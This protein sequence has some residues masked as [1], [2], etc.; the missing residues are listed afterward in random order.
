MGYSP[1]QDS[2]WKAYS[3]AT[4]IDKPVDR[5]YT[6]RSLDPK[7]DPRL[8]TLRESCDSVDH[9]LSTPI[10]IGLDVTGS[11]D[12]I[13]DTTAQKL[14]LLVEKIHELKP[15]TDP[16]IMFN[17]I[18]DSAPGGDSTAPLQVTQ[19]ET[20]IKIAEQ[21]TTL[22]FEKGGGGNAFESYPLT[23]YFA[24]T[25]TKI[26]SFEKRGKKG[27][28]FTM[29]DDGY[30]DR[31]TKQE[32]FN[33]FGETVEKDITTEAILAMVNRQYEVFHLNFSRGYGRGNINSW[34]T[35]LGERAIDVPDH[36]KIPEII[37]SIL[38]S[39]GGKSLEAIASNWDGG[40]ALVI[41]E[42]LGGLTAKSGSNENGLVD[43]GVI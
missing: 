10:I 41:K 39:V 26:D 31:L 15:V 4:I 28:I 11:M 14:G 23:W 16:Q 9:P 18:G 34:K 42:A 35:L 13:L 36:T 30:P 1:W 24:A 40:T 8:I 33:V 21:L 19:F 32:I 3:T 25:R 27:F 7:F 38:E 29:G 20:D 2:D 12:G 17:A 37:V 6:S 5:I 43:F 22:W